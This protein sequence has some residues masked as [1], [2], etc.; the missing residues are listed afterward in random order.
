VGGGEQT[1]LNKTFP[2]ITAK[3]TLWVA[4]LPDQLAHQGDPTREIKEAFYGGLSKPFE[5]AGATLH[6][7]SLPKTQSVAL[8]VKVMEFEADTLTVFEVGKHVAEIAVANARL[9]RALTALGFQNTDSITKR[10][11]RRNL[12]RCRE[13]SAKLR[14]YLHQSEVTLPSLFSCLFDGSPKRRRPHS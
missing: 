12:G 4:V 8:G 3:T 2:D 9:I 14:K 6:F 1:M 7:I 11:L 13:R 5:K 10:F